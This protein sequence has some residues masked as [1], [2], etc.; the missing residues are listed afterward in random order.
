MTGH[1]GVTGLRPEQA[2]SRGQG[3]QP[4][5]A[6]CDVHRS[7]SGDLGDSRACES[8]VRERGRDWRLVSLSHRREDGTRGCERIGLGSGRQA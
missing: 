4:Y 7:L 6:F 8:E 5:V 1:P 3:A 2:E